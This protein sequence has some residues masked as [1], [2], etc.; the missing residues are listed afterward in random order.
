ME[1]LWDGRLIYRIYQKIAA[2]E[3][4]LPF[5]LQED[6]AKLHN[7]IGLKT[8]IPTDESEELLEQLSPSEDPSKR[9]LIR[10]IELFDVQ[11][12]LLD[13]FVPNIKKVFFYY[14]NTN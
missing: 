9:L 12:Q 1:D 3:K 4:I 13:E 10:D 2:K 8:S 5:R 14:F 11:N 6:F 7:E